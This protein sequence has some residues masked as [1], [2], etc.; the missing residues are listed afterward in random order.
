MLMLRYP[1]G[2]AGIALLLMRLSYAVVV[3]VALA[4]LWPAQASD[5]LLIVLS[6]MVSLAIVT[7]AGTRAAAMLLF[8]I[9]VVDMLTV[10]GESALH[11]LASAGGVA[12]LVLLGPGA[13][14]ID[15]Q[16]YGRRV[17]RLEPRSPDRGGPG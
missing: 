14:S 2:V 8:A 15:A 9:L 7:G 16:R 3:F 10:R 13:Y 6:S 1:D 4:R 17:I 5:W 12:A 11:F